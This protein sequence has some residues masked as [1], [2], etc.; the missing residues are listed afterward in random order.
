[1]RLTVQDQ[2][3]DSASH[4]VHRSVAGDLN[5]ACLE[6][7]FDFADLRTIGKARDRERLVRDAGKWTLQILW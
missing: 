1:M 7:D 3:I 5:L 2:R 6:I 4:I